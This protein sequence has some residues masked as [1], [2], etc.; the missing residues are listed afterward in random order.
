[1]S[2]L[3]LNI[4]KGDEVRV[5]S[6]ASRGGQGKVMHVLTKAGR[7]VVEGVNLRP[8]HV[9]ARKQREKGQI[10]EAPRSMHLSDVQLVCSHCKK[11]TRVGRRVQDKGTVR[12]CK[13]CGETLS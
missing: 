1:M 12:V 11:L 8:K 6:G 3:K 5:I 13:K 9:R 7:V 2:K 10:V 4:K